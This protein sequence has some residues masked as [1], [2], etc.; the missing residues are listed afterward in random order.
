VGLVEIPAGIEPALLAPI[1]VVQLVVS[2]L[3]PELLLM[4]IFISFPRVSRA[5]FFIMTM[6]ATAVPIDPT[7]FLPAQTARIPLFASSY[8]T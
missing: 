8:V 1:A 2:G 3:L 5:S 4:S 6:E 7:G